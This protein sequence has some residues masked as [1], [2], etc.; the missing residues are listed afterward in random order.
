MQDADGEN[1]VSLEIYYDKLAIFSSESTRRSGRS[2]PTRC[3]T[4][5]T[6]CCAAPARSRPWPALQYGSGDVLYLSQ[7]G[8]RSI[9]ARDASNSGAVSDIGSP[10]DFEIQN[11]YT[12]SAPLVLDRPKRCWSRL[13]AGS[14]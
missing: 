13:S 4:S 14:G 10:I 3:R 11:L 1:L 7:T 8:I 9:K 5:S 6:R 2:T 12:S